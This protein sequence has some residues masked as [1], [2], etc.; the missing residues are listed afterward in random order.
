MYYYIKNSTYTSYR[1]LI[2]LLFVYSNLFRII[3]IFQYIYIKVL[4]QTYLCIT[5]TSKFRS[6]LSILVS[7]KVAIT[8][9]IASK[10]YIY[11]VK[12]SQ[13]TK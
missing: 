10:N 5:I 9:Y 6:N 3:S 8:Y 12:T 4:Q 2:I 13:T 7:I 1:K 11:S